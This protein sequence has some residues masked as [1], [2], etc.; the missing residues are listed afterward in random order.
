[1]V[2]MAQVN[3]ALPALHAEGDKHNIFKGWKGRTVLHAGWK[4][5]MK[6]K[7]RSCAKHHGIKVL[8]GD[9]TDVPSGTSTA[10]KKERF[11]LCLELYGR[12]IK[13]D[14]YQTSNAGVSQGQGQEI[15]FT[16]TKI[17]DRSET[18]TRNTGPQNLLRVTANL[19]VCT[20][21]STRNAGCSLR[22]LFT[23]CG[24]SEILFSTA[25]HGQFRTDP[26]A[27]S[28]YHVGN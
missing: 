27:Y 1:M 8:M 7:A 6:T 9:M 28:S 25:C 26:Y 18:L 14:M 21:V 4:D 5:E 11:E 24:Q 10:K 17:K 2:V 12:N 15:P 13:N 16:Q 20:T 19:S 22:S 3:N 23:S